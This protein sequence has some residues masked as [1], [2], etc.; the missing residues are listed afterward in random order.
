MF[1]M[2]RMIA[3]VCPACMAVMLPAHARGF[4]GYERGRGYEYVSFGSYPQG[5]QGEALPYRMARA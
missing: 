2:K 4:R 3:A 5:E 1:V